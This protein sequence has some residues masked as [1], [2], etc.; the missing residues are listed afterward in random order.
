LVKFQV[1]T[2]ASMKMTGFWD[3][4]PCSLINTNRHF[5]GACWLLHQGND[6]SPEPEISSYI[7]SACSSVL[8]K[9][10][11]CFYCIH[12]K[13]VVLLILFLYPHTF[14]FM[15][16]MLYLSLH[17]TSEIDFRMSFW[18]FVSRLYL[19][20]T[21]F[22]KTDFIFHSFSQLPGQRWNLSWKLGW[23]A[24]CRHQIYW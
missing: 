19:T 8:G 6:S 3:V 5:R 16:F 2:A 11:E 10:L 7:S 22:Y 15:Y 23:M 13:H 20:V 21:H 24:K 9:P 4:V 17:I 14:L 12:S 1:I 18:L